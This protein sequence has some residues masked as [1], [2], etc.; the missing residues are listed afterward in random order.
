MNELCIQWRS[1]DK[2]VT[3]STNYS[4]IIRSVSA[5]TDCIRLICSLAAFAY[6][7]RLAIPF[8]AYTTCILK[9]ATL[10]S[11]HKTRES[12]RRPPISVLLQYTKT[13]R[14]PGFGSP[15][16]RPSMCLSFFLCVS[17]SL[18]DRPIRY[19]THDMCTVSLAP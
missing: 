11:L 18:S 9:A 6:Y 10:F 19:R 2:S 4:R 8:T 16:F 1:F 12:Q 3:A 14:C 15:P 7:I 5:C 13:K 17:I